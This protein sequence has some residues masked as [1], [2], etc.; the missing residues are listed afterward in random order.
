MNATFERV[1]FR[2]TDEV[3]REDVA[4]RIAYDV[5]EPLALRTAEALRGW[6]RGGDEEVALRAI[7]AL[8]DCLNGGTIVLRGRALRAVAE[9][10]ILTAE[11][12]EVLAHLREDCIR[13]VRASDGDIEALKLT[14]T[15]E[16]RLTDAFR[17]YTRDLDYPAFDLAFETLYAE[18]FG[19]LRDQTRYA[20]LYQMGLRLIDEHERQA[21]RQADCVVLGG[22][23]FP[24]E[25]A[26]ADSYDRPCDGCSYIH[27]GADC[28]EDRCCCPCHCALRATRILPAEAE[29]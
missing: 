4:R 7:A 5:S 16:R 14:S 18:C 2:F 17:A 3:G 20:A 11:E 23:V 15:V 26:S 25:D 19:L 28:A 21:I 22:R 8:S 13:V 24:C 29:G 12:R 9:T 6:I 27:A 10:R 1:E